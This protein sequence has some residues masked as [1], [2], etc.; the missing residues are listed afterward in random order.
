MSDC[1]AQA[2]LLPDQNPLESGY[3]T[4][5]GR[6]RGCG[7]VANS[8]R[9][10]QGKRIV[11]EKRPECFSGPGR[12]PDLSEEE[13]DH[14][15]AF[16][17]GR[18]M[19]IAITMDNKEKVSALRM[20]GAQRASGIHGHEEG[21]GDRL[22]A[23]PATGRWERMCISS[24][25]LITVEPCGLYG[26]GGGKATV[27]PPLCDPGWSQQ[28]SNILRPQ[29]I[30]EAVSGGSM[31]ALPDVGHESHLLS[32]TGFCLGSG[33]RSSR[34]HCPL[35]SLRGVAGNRAGQYLLLSPSPAAPGRNLLGE[36]PELY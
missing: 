25:E 36:L 4:L 19:Q 33:S 8:S 29:E 12:V 5:Q 17:R 21:H 13:T 9:P 3:G 26:R 6:A 24:V 35:D 23:S 18:R 30:P 16:R 11:S 32:L 20:A 31:E 10:F 28:L 22:G 34:E 15:V 7:G 1:L 2:S 14:L 27:P